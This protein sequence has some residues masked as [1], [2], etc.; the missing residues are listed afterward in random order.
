MRTSSIDKVRLSTFHNVADS[1]VIPFPFNIFTLVIDIIAENRDTYLLKEH[2][3]VNHSFLQICSKHRFATV[4]LHE[5]DPRNYTTSLPINRLVKLLKSR[6][7][8]DVVKNIRKLTAT[9]LF[10]RSRAFMKAEITFTNQAVGRDFLV[11]VI[12]E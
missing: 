9:C 2:T 12:I 5:P 6:P 4:E 7:D 3:V 10:A 11:S 8:S 1:P